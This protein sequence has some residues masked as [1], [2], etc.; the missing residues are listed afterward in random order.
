MTDNI[1]LKVLEAYTRD[2]GRAVARIDYQTMDSIK[3]ST[4]DIIEVIGKRR[5]VAKCLPLY[6]S[7]EG[8]GIIRLDGLGRY[9]AGPAIVGDTV[10]IDKIKTYPAQHVVV[11][12]LEAIPPID[13]RYL[14]DALESVPIVV[15]DNV[16]V[17]YF[18]GRLTFTVFSITA[19][20]TVSGNNT[21]D[22][23]VA[24]SSTNTITNNS[25]AVIVTQQTVFR[26]L[27]REAEAEEKEREK[28]LQ[29]L[30]AV[31]KLVNVIEQIKASVDFLVED[32]KQQI[33]A[34][35]ALELELRKLNVRR[36]IKDKFFGQKVT[37]D[38][39]VINDEGTD[40]EWDLPTEVTK[41]FFPTP[42]EFG[43]EL[44]DRPTGPEP[45]KEEKD[46][47]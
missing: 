24:T 32:R 11:K 8:K 17:P 7:D 26:I 2:V 40:L 45:E 30:D 37:N 46:N 6:P 41:D 35:K 31:N 4:G 25:I 23:T 33:V 43:E 14:A 21:I 34:Q 1:Q 42:P 13:E 19:N 10:T 22:D 44:T 39:L 38:R 12:P 9:N 20:V 28:H 15:G 18:G 5:T 16:M 36:G 3:A 27:D 29:H 47:K